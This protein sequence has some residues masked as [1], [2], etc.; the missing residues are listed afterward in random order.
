MAKKVS[1][2]NSTLSINGKIVIS[3][4]NAVVSVFDRGFLYGDSLYEVLRTENAHPVYLEDHLRRLVDS[5]KLWLEDIRKY[6]PVYRKW[7]LATLKN[8]FHSHSGEAYVRTI[9]TRGGGQIGFSRKAISTSPVFIIIVQPLQKFSN[10]DVHRGLSLAISTRLR[11]DPRALDPAMKSGNYL[12]S[13]LAYLDAE[14][15][16]FDDAILCNHEGFVTEGTTFNIWYLRNNRVATPPLEIGILDGITRRHTLEILNKMSIETREI[17]F[18]PERL[19]D[20]D[21][22]FVTSSIKD[23][24]P[25]TQLQNKKWPKAGRFTLQ[26]RK[27]FQETVMRSL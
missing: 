16:G 3:P 8:Y 1:P 10:A 27:R 21:E 6:V 19:L 14:D 7:I 13:L 2:F 9:L 20:A 12:N 24:F 25:V 17:R 26:L 22:V 5:G 18:K 23:V 11:N 4:Q 15:H